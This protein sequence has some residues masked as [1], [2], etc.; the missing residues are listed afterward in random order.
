MKFTGIH[1]SFSVTLNINGFIFPK[2]KAQTSRRDLK[3]VL[4][5]SAS[6]KYT[7]ESEIETTLERRNVQR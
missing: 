4:P 5:F 3:E 1:T 7:S 6:K 2:Q